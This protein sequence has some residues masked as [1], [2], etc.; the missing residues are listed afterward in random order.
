ML[1]EGRERV[2]SR[3]CNV[4]NSP[5]PACVLATP[6]Y[7]WLGQFPGGRG[8]RGAKQIHMLVGVLVTLGQI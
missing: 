2:L 1:R 8:E 7:T 6:F 5:R 3:A 4:D